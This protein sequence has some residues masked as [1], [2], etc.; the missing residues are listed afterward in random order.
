MH[1]VRSLE[2]GD[3]RESRRTDKSSSQGSSKTSK[4]VEKARDYLVELVGSEEVVR[5]L[6]VATLQFAKGNSDF[7]IKRCSRQQ[8]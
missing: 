8:S 6:S 2:I 4:G 3:G 1:P 7:A 5:I